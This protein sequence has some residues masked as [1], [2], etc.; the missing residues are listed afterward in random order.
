ML[1][2]VTD[3]QRMKWMQTVRAAA[4]G[5]SGA[6]IYSTAA[7]WLAKSYTAEQHSNS[8]FEL[9][10]QSI[11]IDFGIKRFPSIV[12]SWEETDKAGGRIT[13][14]YANHSWG[15]LAQAAD[16]PTTVFHIKASCC[17]SGFYGR[18]T[19]S[20]PTYSVTIGKVRAVNQRAIVLPI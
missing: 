16:L 17:I 4:F 12:N 9:R 6:A 18:F 15:H 19:A 13:A 10:P 7:T 14:S 3:R 5:W 1:V 11:F 2:C 8:T 20:H